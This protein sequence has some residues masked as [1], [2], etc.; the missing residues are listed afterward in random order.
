[1]AP[2]LSSSS[3]LRL[4]FSIPFLVF[5]FSCSQP[6]SGQTKYGDVALKVASILESEHYN[7]EPFDDKMSAK[8][9]DAYIEMLDFRRVYF[10]Q[11]DIDAFNAKYRHTIDDNI[12]E[13]GIPAAGEIYGVYLER[14][15]SRVEYAEKILNEEKFTFDSDRTVRI[16][17]KDAPWPGNSDEEQQIWRNLI[18]EELLRDLLSAE[19]AKKAAIELGEE[20]KERDNPRAKIL[21][22]YRDF[23]K[24]IVDNDTE[25]VATIFIK[26]VARAYD[27]HSEYYSRKQYENFKIGMNKKLQGIGAMLRLDEDEIPTVEGLV[28]GGPAAKQGDLKNQDKIVG[29][30][31]GEGEIVDV[32]GKKLSDT[33]DLIRGDIG[34]TVTL[35]VRPAKAAD[36]SQTS[37]IKIVRD[38]VDLKDSLATADLIITQ[39]PMGETQKVGWIRLSSFY[40]DMDGGDTSTTADVR[41]L[42]TRL[43]IEGMDGLVIDLRDNGGGSLEEAVNMTGLFINKGPVVQAQN[44]RGQRTQKVSKNAN[45]AYDGPMIVLTN[46]ASASASE[47]FA[48]ALQDYNR[49]LIIGEKSTFGKGTVQQLRPV[50]GSKFNLFNRGNAEQKGAL[51]LTIQTFFR[52]NGESTQLKGVIPDLQLPSIYDVEDFGEASLSNPLKVDPIRPANYNLFSHTPLP[53]EALRR[54]MEPR[55]ASDKDFGYIIQ[56]IAEEKQRL[57]ENRISLN[58][59]KRQTEVEKNKAEGEARKKERIARYKD[60]REEEKNLFSVF[61][62]TQDNF[63]DRNL[64]LKSEITS[65]AL[66]GMSRGEDSA[67]DDEDK[68]LEY[69]HLLDPYERETIRVMQDFIAIRET[70]KPVNISS[71]ARARRAALEPIA[72]GAQ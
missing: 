34:S 18:E 50:Y 12:K 10:T 42:L 32:I 7:R 47:I 35:R 70:G 17:R 31:Q 66:S 58:K 27:P 65:E 29:V 53:V 46:R 37:L 55:I 40:S 67:E 62:I 54:S 72:A 16:T 30:G 52:I 51:K 33:V 25:D 23:L 21:K 38:Q 36:P 4:L 56:D 20:P 13:E 9:L 60:I 48:A 6:V 63:A 1:M 15:R 69:P 3:N 43:R 59:E 2:N 24:G 14:V 68:L 49:A 57:H 45:P 71:V 26:A 22:R 41:R 28:V 64:T 8:V 19:A 5:A 11:Q 61:T 44:W 39:D